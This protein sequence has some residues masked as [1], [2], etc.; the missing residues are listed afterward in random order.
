MNATN[1]VGYAKRV[2]V[3]PREVTHMTTLDSTIPMS[4]PYGSVGTVRRTKCG[5]GVGVETHP[6]TRFDLVV[7]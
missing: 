4:A 1:R 5:N 6:R 2:A 3:T 7:A